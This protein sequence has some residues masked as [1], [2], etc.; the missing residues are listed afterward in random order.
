MN[1]FRAFMELDA[2]NESCNNRLTL[3]DNIKKSGHNYN[4]DKYS[5]EQLYRIWQRIQMDQQEEQDALRDYYNSKVEKPTCDNC[6]TSL[7]DGGYCPVCDDGAEDIYEELEYCWFG[8]YLDKNG[9]KKIIYATKQSTSYDADEAEELLEERIPEPYT[10]FV[11]RGRID[12]VTAEAEGWQLVECVFDYN[13]SDRSGWVT[14]SGTPVTLQKPLATTSTKSNIAAANK[15]IVT[16][17]RDPSKGNKLRAQADDGVNGRGWVAFPNNLRNQEGQQYEVDG[18]VWNGKNYR[19][20]GNINPITNSNNTTVK[21]AIAVTSNPDLDD[22][23]FCAVSRSGTPT[24]TKY[25]YLS[26][27]TDLYSSVTDAEEDAK[28]ILAALSGLT[29]VYIVQVN[30]G[31]KAKTIKIVYK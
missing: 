9:N 27:V 29:E 6:G 24:T 31:L 1:M 18:L 7:T 5:D 21:Y 4:F 26:D 15:Q 12:S 10:K 20:V 13:P 8:Y 3:I 23:V 16:I 30:N 14:V 11:F 17:V 25:E 2:I 28:D 22:Y 19:V